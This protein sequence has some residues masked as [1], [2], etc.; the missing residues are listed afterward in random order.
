MKKKIA[1]IICSAFT[2]GQIILPSI[3]TYASNIINN[4]N[5]T[6]EGVEL[7]EAQQETSNKDEVV[8]EEDNKDKDVIEE[9][10]KEVVQEEN[11]ENIENQESKNEEVINKEDNKVKKEQKE[12]TKYQKVKKPLIKSYSNKNDFHMEKKEYEDDINAL[13]SIEYLVPKTE[14]KYEIALAYSDGSY[15]YVSAKDNYSEAVNVAKDYSEKA[16]SSDAIP[17]V[18]NN[19]G[20][21]VYSTNAMGRVIKH[22]NGSPYPGSD[23]TTNIYKNENKT[24][25]TAYINHGYIDDV[26][27][28]QDNGTMAKIQAGGF[29]GWINK[30]INSSE[31]DLVIVPMN[32]VK[33]PSYYEVVNGELRH[34]ISSDI[35]S[36]T[37]SGYSRT[38][39]IAPS[40]LKA[41]NKYYS[42]DNTYFYTSLDT[43]ISD[44]REG[45]N[46]N[47]VNAGDPFYLYYLSLP[48]RSKTTYSSS[49]I[50]SFINKNTKSDSALRNSGQAFI[51]AQ[52]KYG[53]NALLMLGVAINESGWGNSSLAKNKNNIFGLEAYDSTPGDAKQ[54]ISVAHC[55]DEFANYWIS[56]GYGD[57]QDWRFYGGFL[58]NKDKGANVKY[59][60]D[61]FWGSKA[62][63]FAYQADRDLGKKDY[64]SEIIGIFTSA[65]EVRAKDGS[66]LY[67]IK[68]SK[69][70]N[71][72]F[73]GVPVI[74][75]SFD[76]Y[77]GNGS[78]WYSIKPDRTTALPSSGGSEFGGVYD[79]NTN[80]YVKSN[81]IK[82]VNNSKKV[83]SPGVKYQSHVQN[84]GWQPWVRNGELSGTSG[85]SLRV[86]GLKINLEGM[87]EG[88][89]IRYRTHV[90]DYG[91]QAWKNEGEFAGTSGES[92]RIEGIQIEKVNF[93]EGYELIYR[94]HVQ[95][96]GW[97]SWKRSGDI[98]GTSGQSLRIE[99]IE[100]KVVKASEPKV[101]YRGHVQDIGWQGYVSNG[102][103]AGTSGQSKRVEALQITLDDS[104]PGTS[105]RYR[106]HVQNI[107][108]QG[109]VQDGD[110]AGTSGQSL[111]IEGIQIE[112]VNAPAGYSIEY[113]THVQDIGWQPWVRDGK[114]AGT[115]GQS[116]RIEAVEIRIVK[117]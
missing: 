15:S 101:S 104:M 87:P 55:I 86:E 61:P 69:S 18:I 107:G 92:K 103:T 77:S 16:K 30:D 66:V 23:K 32:Q 57:P 41:G 9:D 21:V 44:L 52:D 47:A 84:V 110:V 98:A 75:N 59:A 35:T 112:L 65:T 28:I 26:P 40:Y 31:Y 91:W 85:K 58:G 24:G 2:L 68:N 1:M 33:N 116:K 72:S 97:Q 4:S 25:E 60:S 95:N 73:V 115:T 36:S 17:V 99:A 89:T 80:G 108:W 63:S 50:D 76:K 114:L 62:A 82:I 102:K 113:R 8:I 6:Q 83:T 37:G 13:S 70:T 38:V 106:T 3:S 105:I 79:W 49:E 88:S 78:Q 74:L 42:Y 45:H 53:V 19:D 93:P 20:Q 56:R 46:N 34:F 64:D 29:T 48:F 27:V 7:E 43:L 96:V 94:T 117:K 12:E 81:S 51:D 22:V 54:F 5:I 14:L 90:Q 10:N 39:G 11:D 67:N 100:I 71:S 111:R 109:W